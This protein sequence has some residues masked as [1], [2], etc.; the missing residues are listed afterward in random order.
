MPGSHKRRAKRSGSLRQVD[1]YPVSRVLPLG[2]V[3]G[4]KA[5][6]VPEPAMEVSEFLC[7][8]AG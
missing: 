3:E 6:T 8:E 7:A 5:D 1:P 4:R 2:G